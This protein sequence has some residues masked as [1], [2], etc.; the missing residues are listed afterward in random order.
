MMPEEYWRLAEECEE[1]AVQTDDSVEKYTYSLLAKQ[2]RQ[3]A[4]DHGQTLHLLDAP[5]SPGISEARTN[6]DHSVTDWPGLSL[7]VSVIRP[8]P[9]NVRFATLVP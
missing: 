7:G 6:S 5:E 4:E 8:H 1:A 9:H 3:L 2:W